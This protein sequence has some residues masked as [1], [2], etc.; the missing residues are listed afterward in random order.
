MI[1]EYEPG[2][3][4]P[5]SSTSRGAPS[6]REGDGLDDDA[7]SHRELVI[8]CDISLAHRLRERVAWLAL[9][10]C[11]EVTEQS[12]FGVEGR[13]SLVIAHGVEDM[14]SALRMLCMDPVLWMTPTISRVLFVS[15]RARRLETLIARIREYHPKIFD[16]GSAL[17]IAAFPRAF[18]LELLCHPEFSGSDSRVRLAARSDRAD[19]ILYAIRRSVRKTKKFGFAVCHAASHL[20]TVRSKIPHAQV[21]A[22]AGD[23]SVCR[24]RYKL[25]EAHLRGLVALP[26]PLELSPH[27]RTPTTEVATRSAVDLGAAPGGWSSFLAEHGCR[28]WA[29]DPAELRVQC[30]AVFTMDGERRER[31]TGGDDGGAN[32]DLHGSVVGDA[33]G[34]D[35]DGD[36]DGEHLSNCAGG[37]G[38]GGGGS[39]SA[40]VDVDRDRVR[41]FDSDGDVSLRADASASGG[42]TASERRSARITHVACRG[43][44]AIGVVSSGLGGGS[45]RSF[46]DIILCDANMLPN[47]ACALVRSYVPFARAG[48]QVVLTAKACKHT[49]LKEHVRE[50]EHSLWAF[51]SDVSVT[52][53][54]TNTQV[55]ENSRLLL[56][57]RHQKI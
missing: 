55:R 23:D 20:G 1:A 53:L 4:A 6:S 33:W 32:F 57:T 11:I 37:D 19:S 41:D 45:H 35:G 47:E 34:V 24:A 42:R 50:V 8:T 12:C 29:V 48:A 5:A 3:P 39:D 2:S 49:H 7:P 44:D 52:H 15:R 36:S 10:G 9:P 13:S 16:G 26:S 30:G 56:S 27:D 51:C 46:L 40:D 22:R 18:E 17:H 54:F 38:N 25:E 14:D 31:D 43:E 21:A 28:V